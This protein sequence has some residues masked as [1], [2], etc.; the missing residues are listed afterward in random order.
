MALQVL[1]LIRIGAILS[2][3]WIDALV[4]QLFDC[5]H[6]SPALRVATDAQVGAR[7]LIVFFASDMQQLRI[8]SDDARGA[9]VY[10]LKRDVSPGNS[11]SGNSVHYVGEP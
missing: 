9:S 5:V 10:V 6:F 2:P 7:S 11:M 8:G 4:I 1:S 3:R